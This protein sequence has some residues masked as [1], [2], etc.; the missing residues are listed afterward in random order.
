MSD[1]EEFITK[2][3]DIDWEAHLA[4]RTNRIKP[5]FLREILKLAI[6]PDIISFAGGMPAPDLFPVREFGCLPRFCRC[7]IVHLLLGLN[8]L[9][10]E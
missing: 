1:T 2:V 5:S 10:W 3:E 9:R 6:Q 8:S 7:V 4:Q